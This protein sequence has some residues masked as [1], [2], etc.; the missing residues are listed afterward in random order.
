MIRGKILFLP[1]YRR[2]ERDLR[3]IIP[4][5]EEKFRTYRSRHT[6][7][8]VFDELI[9]FGMDDIKHLFTT[10]LKSITDRERSE[11]NDLIGSYLSQVLHGLGEQ[12]DYERITKFKSDELESVISRIKDET[13]KAGDRTH[14]RSVINRIPGLR[15][16]DL[17][18]QERYV[19]LFFENLVTTSRNLERNEVGV[20]KLASV[21]NKYLFGKAII[22]NKKDSVIEIRQNMDNSM[23]DLAD[24]SSGEKQIV[25][26][27]SHLCLN[28]REQ[29]IVLIDEPELSL[30][31][32]WQR[33][34]LPDIWNTERCSFLAAVTH[35]PFIFDNSFDSYAQDL[36]DRLFPTGVQSQADEETVSANNTG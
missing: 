20:T 32:E 17:R 34:L 19:A 27:F 14:L 21:C 11:F 28:E 8:S 36:Q 35:S 6:S 31:V 25:A 3:Y 29:F 22:Y 5:I 18:E 12:F 30:G 7:S 2:S 26:L 15:P 23:I 33:T 13:L 16:E 4:D 9:E 10:K 24:L 1:T